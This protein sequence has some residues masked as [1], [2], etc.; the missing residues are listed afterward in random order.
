MKP[1][2]WTV[3]PSGLLFGSEIRALL[4]S[5]LVQTAPDRLGIQCYRMASYV[6]AP[7]T[8]FAGLEKLPAGGWLTVEA[9]DTVL[10]KSVASHF[11]ADISIDALVSGAWDSSIIADLA[12]QYTPNGLSTFSIVF[13]EDPVLNEAAYASRVAT[14][15][16]SIHR[17][18][19]FRAAEIPE[20]LPEV[21]RHL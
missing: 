18:I 10:R 6:P 15:L 16:S 5:G 8:G 21:I 3:T 9:L 7:R 19:E 11:S 17:E 1:L 14:P 12:A 2:Y 4:A 20:L 13:H